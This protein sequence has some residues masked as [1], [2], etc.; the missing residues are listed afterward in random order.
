MI[1]IPLQVVT[2]ISSSGFDYTVYF[3]PI[4]LVVM[5]IVSIALRVGVF[6]AVCGIFLLLFAGLIT[7]NPYVVVNTSYMANGT[8]LIAKTQFFMHPYM[9]IAL[10]F[11]GLVCLLL[12]VS[13]YRNS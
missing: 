7:A 4:I 12:A 2:D 5:S 1:T 11:F 10:A 3:I 13:D 9:E 6:E 8:L